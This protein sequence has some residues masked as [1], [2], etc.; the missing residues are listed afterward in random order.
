MDG[1]CGT[2]GCHIF[3]K[4]KGVLHLIAKNTRISRPQKKLLEREPC[5]KKVTSVSSTLR[6]PIKVVPC[7]RPPVTS[8]TRRPGTA[9]WAAVTALTSS[10]GTSRPTPPSA[11]TSV[12]GRRVR[13]L[14]PMR[15]S[16]GSYAQQCLHNDARNLDSSLQCVQWKEHISTQPFSWFFN[17]RK[18][19]SSAGKKTAGAAVNQKKCKPSK[20]DL[21]SAATSQ[22]T[23]GRT[24]RCFHAPA[25][26]CGG[27]GQIRLK[28][29]HSDKFH[30]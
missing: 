6:H 10:A 19:P 25:F 24:P 7:P 28:K 2:F 12:T 30:G 26:V 22:C 18:K 27:G 5:L 13:T 16:V 21:N 11:L 17:H 3:N 20:N 9:G 14:A 1:F 4:C 23:L 29:N 15:I 8:V